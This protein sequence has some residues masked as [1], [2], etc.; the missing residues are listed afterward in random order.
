MLLLPEVE[1]CHPASELLGAKLSLNQYQIGEQ[2][3][4]N[5]F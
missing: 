4:G 1:D 5:G 3:E 2:E